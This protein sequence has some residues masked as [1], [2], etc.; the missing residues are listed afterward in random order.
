MARSEVTETKRRRT[1]G[2]SVSII[3]PA[4]LARRREEFLQT[5]ERRAYER[6]EQRGAE[7]GSHE[8]DWL[9][10]ERELSR[11]LHWTLV[12]DQNGVRLFVEVPGFAPEQLKLYGCDGILLLEAHFHAESPLAGLGHSHLGRDVYQFIT[13]PA[14]LAVSHATLDLEHGI[15]Q[16]QLPF[17]AVTGEAEAVRTAAPGTG[18]T[19]RKSASAAVKS[20][21]NVAAKSAA[22]RPKT[23]ARKKTPETTQEK[24]KK[25][26]E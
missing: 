23:T 6:F 12:E 25:T 17:A 19:R 21:R 18:P 10:A 22:V 15:L 11:Q 2:A 16:I 9:Q 13:L 8:D 20:P 26:A 24:L 3:S 5:V 4:E 7:H 14:G 1:K